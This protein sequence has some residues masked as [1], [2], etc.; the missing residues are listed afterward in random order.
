MVHLHRYLD[1]SF[2]L[3]GHKE[4]GQELD[5]CKLSYSVVGISKICAEALGEYWGFFSPGTCSGN[6]LYVCELAWSVKF[7]IISKNVSATEKDLTCGI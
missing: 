2:V 1:I 7:W 3:D 6:Q 5:V 4:R